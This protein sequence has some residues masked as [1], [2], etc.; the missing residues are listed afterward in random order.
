M[1]KER[2]AAII[3]LLLALPAQAEVSVW[4]EASLSR[5]RAY[6]QEALVYTVSI[7]SADN[8]RRVT[9]IPPY[10]QGISIEKLDGPRT[11][12]EEIAGKRYILSE[13]RYALTPLVS[14]S[15]TL[16]PAEI[17]VEPR[18][19]RDRS[20]RPI[21]PFVIPGPPAKGD[22]QEPAK[23][24]TEKVYLV[25]F[26]PFRQADPWLP[27]RSFNLTAR[28]SKTEVPRA[29]EPVRLT[30]EIT[31]AGSR[32][33]RLPS[34][35]PYLRPAN[36]SVYQA[37]AHTDWMITAKGDELIGRRIETYTLVPRR[38]GALTVP[39]L[40]VPWWDAVG[41]RHA[42]SE[43]PAQTLRVGAAQP[44]AETPDV[45]PKRSQE[46]PRFS[47]QRVLRQV[48]LPVAGSF[49][50]AL[51]AGW[52]IVTEPSVAAPTRRTLPFVRQ[53]G[54]GKTPSSV[55]HKVVGRAPG[56]PPLS[57][58]F[59]AAPSLLSMGARRR[60]RR[61]TRLRIPLLW[62]WVRFLRRTD[63]AGI[64]R[65]LRGFAGANLGMSAN[66]PLRRI[67]QGLAV[68]P[69]CLEEQ[70]LVRL[71]ECLDAAIYGKRTV[72]L[73]GW[74]RELLRCFAAARAD[75]RGRDSSVPG[76]EL[77]VLNP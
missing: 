15:L 51:L 42:V 40:R 49:A 22:D 37:G 73:A 54:R 29:G 3:L 72:E 23:V 68:P 57:G 30:L 64:A 20:R 24:T 65:L 75:R 19:T 46:V 18:E 67:A 61:A 74:K 71:F 31:A 43:V 47:W 9:V 52:W 8:L 2:C 55:P 34:L 59:R 26:P 41:N 63:P 77:P 13:F 5:D 70:R 33:S 17:M 28:W 7:F 1:V 50:F 32:G 36:I 16:T 25:V 10:H 38:Q 6:V 45:Q 48:V 35:A 11:R 14:G 39:A 44:T 76:C 56:K 12:A 69:F 21:G 53:N 62:L 58:Q 60:R 66:V 4:A 27:L